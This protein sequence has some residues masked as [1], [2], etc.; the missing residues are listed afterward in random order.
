MIQE[1]IQKILK[2][3]IN[4]LIE[5][6]K[7]IPQKEDNLIP[8]EKGKLVCPSDKN[9]LEKFEPV[10]E[11]PKDEAHGDFASN[12]AMLLAKI[13]KRPP[14]AIGEILAQSINDPVI[15]KIELAGPG[16]LNFFLTN[17]A[18]QSVVKEVH[19]QG[20]SWGHTNIG[21]GKKIL[22]EFV[23][24]NP[25]GPL[26]VVSARAATIGDIIAN[27][28]SACGYKAEREYYVNDEGSQ[29]D[30][31]GKSLFARFSQLHG[32]EVPIPEDGYYGEYLI[33]I[34]KELINEGEGSSC[35]TNQEFGAEWSALAVSHLLKKQ[36]KSLSEF[37][38]NF[39]KFF[40]QSE[41]TKNNKHLESLNYLKENGFVYEKEG[42]LWFT[43][44][45][46]GDNQDRV[47]VRSSGKHTY[48]SV[49]ISYHLDK[50]QRRYYRLINLIGP[51]HHGYIPRLKAA[52]QALGYPNDLLETYIV[53]QVT[54]IK[55]GQPVKMS[56]RAGEFI[57]MED[58][59]DEVGVY[60][61]RF[62][63]NLRHRDSPLE[64]D[65]D[66]AKE[67][68]EKNPLY[69]VQYAHARIK[70]I[71]RNAQEEGISIPQNIGKLNLINESDLK[72]LIAKEELSLLKIISRF[73][74]LVR[75]CME[76][77]ETHH[78][79]AYGIDLAR[80][81]H[82]FYTAHRVLGSGDAA[83]TLARLAL[84]NAVAITIANLLALMGISA[85]DKM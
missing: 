36:R 3:A 40:H 47:L 79:A 28:F 7:L 1:K 31:L 9:L 57:T 45:K 11:I 42:A 14:K 48:F 49:D 73:P 74:S 65:L 39:N 21:E 56:K 66:L 13:M 50:A 4:K 46:F 30:N 71:L 34:A 16:F 27:L 60:A 77:R 51:D 22:L 32:K 41:L 12:T 67:Q 85:P 35:S 83:L 75:D 37:G 17:E 5:E 70:S 78:L 8:Q 58:L 15:K 23:S 43:A 64:F 53:Q 76:K 63:F 2:E 81:F 68:S 20:N 19:L 44:T 72:P 25:T 84:I 10:V 26:N 55:S 18:F 38:V 6:G 24:A 33:D 82:A 69:Y 62:F 29:I 54:L 80:A 59:L 52:I 61:A